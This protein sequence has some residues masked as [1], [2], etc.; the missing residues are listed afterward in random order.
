MGYEC[1]YDH[2]VDRHVFGPV[3]PLVS[4]LL[5]DA[6]GKKKKDEIFRRKADK[7]EHR[8]YERI[9]VHRSPKEQPKEDII[10][11]KETAGNV[12]IGWRR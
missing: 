4:H 10:C 3:K 8:E 9:L 7:N 6:I 1:I 5:Y 11:V 2:T 12:D